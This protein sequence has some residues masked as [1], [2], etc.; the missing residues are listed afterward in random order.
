MSVGNAGSWGKKYDIGLAL[1][2]GAQPGGYMGTVGLVGLEVAV[3]VIAVRGLA[4]L[5]RRR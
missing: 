1:R 2:A 3:V 4:W 5:L